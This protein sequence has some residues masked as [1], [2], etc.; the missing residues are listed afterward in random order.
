MA[1]DMETGKKIENQRWSA[2]GGKREWG[3]KKE[4]TE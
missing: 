4:R 2:H 1:M 3:K